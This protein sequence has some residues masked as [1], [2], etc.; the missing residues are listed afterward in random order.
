MRGV[1]CVACSCEDAAIN[2]CTVWLRVKNWFFTNSSKIAL[3]TEE[4]D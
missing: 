4:A 3:D 1:L 2:E